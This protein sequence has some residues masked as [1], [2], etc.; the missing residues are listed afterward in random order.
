[1]G[2]T[3]KVLVKI[4]QLLVSNID[5]EIRKKLLKTYVWSV[6]LYGYEA[7]T[8]GKEERRLQAFEMWYYRKLV[9]IRWV[10]KVTNEKVLNVVK[11]KISLYAS[12]KR[13]RDKIIGHIVRY[14]GLTGT[15][16]ECTV[17][18]RKR[19]GDKD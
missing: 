18:G 12:I 14:E 3:K 16:L 10:D 5:L 15:V 17:E 11:K 8:I 2:Q 7:W 6:T 4:P 13:R 19:K 9:K 1:M